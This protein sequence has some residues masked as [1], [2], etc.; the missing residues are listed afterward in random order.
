MRP[1]PG[2][3]RVAHREWDWISHD[4]TALILIFGVPIFAILVLTAVFSHPVMR[5]LGIVV[6]DA[7]RSET[8]RA[9]VEQVAASPGLSIVERAGDLT[10]AVRAIRSGKALGA[11]YVPAHFERDL[12][13]AR[14]PQIVAFYNQQFLTAAGVA[15]SSLRDS[16]SA[17]V[18]TAAAP[19][20]PKAPAIGSLIAETIVLVNPAR[21][22]AQF[23]LRAL[24]A[25]GASRRDSNFRR[26]CGGV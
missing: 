8:S 23:L 14:R 19:V 7:D 5:G 25:H 26:L 22:Y 1:R 16:L 11:I 20:A 4:R 24:I 10:S 9:F 6:V 13:A 15:V 21:N 3:L 12:K 18:R 2:F 17:A